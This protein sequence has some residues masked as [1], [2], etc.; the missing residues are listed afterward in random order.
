[1]SSRTAVVHYVFE[2]NPA[3]RGA[4]YHRNRRRLHPRA[5]ELIVADSPSTSY[6]GFPDYFLELLLSKV[7]KSPYLWPRLR[8]PS[9]AAMEAD[10]VAAMDEHKLAPVLLCLSRK[11][12]VLLTTLGS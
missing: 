7:A 3:S 1:M 10:L 6:P 11:P 9:A 5:P 8:P 4:L 12:V 2:T